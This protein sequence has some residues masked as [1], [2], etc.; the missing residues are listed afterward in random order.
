MNILACL[1]PQEIG[2]SIA[3]GY[4]AAV[5]AIVATV[6]S[7][8]LDWR[9]GDFRW[10]PICG[11]LLILHPAWTMSEYMGDCGYAKRFMSAAISVVFAAVLLCQIFRRQLR[12]RRFFLALSAV[13]WLAFA[14]AQLYWQI[15]DYTSVIGFLSHVFSSAGIEAFLF[16]SPVLFRAAIVVSVT[17]ALLYAFSWSRRP[18]RVG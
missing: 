14:A 13:C 6:V 1:S 16:A 12:I 5:F 18:P 15:V 10:L 7:V 3:F 2:I 11:A 9:R 8:I 17:C 4:Y